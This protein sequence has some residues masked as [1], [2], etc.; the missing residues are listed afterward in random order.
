[1]KLRYCGIFAGV[2]L[3]LLTGCGKQE[4]NQMAIVM[5]VGFD[6]APD[7][8][9]V[10]VTAEMVRPAEARGQSGISSGGS[11]RPTW[12]VS[13]KGESIFEAIRNMARFTS[14]RIFWAHNKI[15]IFGED[16][17]RQGITDALD[18]LTRNHELRMNTWV[19]VTPG[20]ASKIVSMQT[21]IET[22]TGD[23]LDRLFRFS[24]FSAAAPKT[25]MKTV[26]ASYLSKNSNPIIAMVDT[27][28]RNRKENSTSVLGD[29]EEVELA[30]TAVFRKEKMLG[31]LN[32][33]ESRA[34]LWFV[35]KARSGIYK[36]PCPDQPK[37]PASLELRD[38][39]FNVIPRYQEDRASFQISLELDMDLVELG[40]PSTMEMEDIITQLEKDASK[41]ISNEIL[42]LLNKAQH[43]YKTDFLELGKVFQNQ[44]P[45]LW[46]QIKGRWT[47]VFSQAEMTVDVNVHVKSPVLLRQPTKPMT[48]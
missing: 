17:A 21:G 46:K 15:V 24:K 4:I 41:M 22:V 47:Q 7:S 2:L 33:K 44:K 3:L 39:R 40:C 31:T 32:D 29:K 6:K 36:L 42:S 12:T 38:S 19:V 30:G 23:S 20:K 18:F 11:G 35:Q 34:L 9:E 1:M 10:I 28:K 5:A 37:L 13:A 26:T 16:Y 25:D 45:H 8:N 27:I 43:V 14:R 48:D